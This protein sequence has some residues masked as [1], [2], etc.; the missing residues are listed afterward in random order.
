VWVGRGTRETSSGGSAAAVLKTVLTAPFP[1][2]NRVSTW[3]VVRPSNSSPEC[4]AAASTSPKSS[5]D[6]LESLGPQLRRRPAPSGKKSNEPRQPF[7][8]GSRDQ[9]RRWG[10]AP[11]PIR[12]A[13]RRFPHRG[14]PALAGSATGT[15][16]E[17][18]WP[19]VCVITRL[20]HTCASRIL[21]AARRLPLAVR[22]K[23]SAVT[24]NALVEMTMFL[25]ASWR[26]PSRVRQ[27]RSG[28]FF[29]QFFQAVPSHRNRLTNGTS[30]LE[31]AAVFCH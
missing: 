3:L 7:P 19:R 2:T 17:H 16:R 30:R 8:R 14:H 6:Y 26:A 28:K 20:H 5:Q 1:D 9:G 18:R 21:L 15:G 23:A 10:L 11:A 29:H 31:G 22:L 27:A 4:A 13:D 25:Y 24:N 12:S